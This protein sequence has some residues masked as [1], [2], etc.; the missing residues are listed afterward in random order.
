MNEKEKISS[1]IHNVKKSVSD[2]DPIFL[3]QL[4]PDGQMTRYDQKFIFNSF[5]IPQITHCLKDYYNI[6]EIEKKR[7]MLY[8][9]EY[10][11]TDDYQMYT[12]HHN[13]K[14]NRFKIRIRKYMETGDT[15]LEVKKKTNKGLM[16]K[17]RIS[18]DKTGNISEEAIKLI[19]NITPYRYDDLRTTIK[20]RFYRLTLQNIC[21]QERITIDCCVELFLGDKHIKLPGLGIMEVKKC[22]SHETSKIQEVLKK[23]VIINTNFS[24]YCTGLAL[25]CNKVKYNNF[26]EKLLTIKR[27]ENE[28]K[29]S[30]ESGITS[31]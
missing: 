12:D 15:F 22:D 8:Q 5:Y 27:F 10:F 21:Q 26:K 7:L 4:T 16:V 28:F 9:S 31:T 11:D 29:L 3:A 19:E 1:L 25:L 30:S 6:L 24:K 2:F 17:K 23:K 14:S 13:G 18:L 20:S